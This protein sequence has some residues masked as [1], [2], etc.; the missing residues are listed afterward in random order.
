MEGFAMFKKLLFNTRLGDWLLATFERLT[1]LAVVE[2][3]TVVVDQF[4]EVTR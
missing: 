3:G 1:G 4:R 2:L